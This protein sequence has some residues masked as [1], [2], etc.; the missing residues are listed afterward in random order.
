MGAGTD[1]RYLGHPNLW[2]PCLM[3]S[4]LRC[5]APG[6]SFTAEVVIKRSRFIATL[7][8]ADS[9]ADARDFV[10]QVKA[11][12]PAARH[13]CS[14]F[15]VELAQANRVERSSDDGEPAGTAGMPMLEVLRSSGLTNVAVVVTRYFGG[16]LLGTGGLVRAY[17]GAV[18]A[19]LDETAVVELRPATRCVLELDHANAGQIEAE[20]RARG[21][22]IAELEYGSKVTLT[23]ACPPAAVAELESEIA[24]RTG[25]VIPVKK[26]NT[27]VVEHP[28]SL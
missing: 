13:N 25:G 15:L 12:Y 8:R 26:A 4:P 28:L 14:A 2:H 11:H 22:Q 6:K 5:P 3:T 21:W 17:S 19:V 27:I 18:Q 9:E 10:T 23:I 20:L 7:Q 16:V 1:R 24:A